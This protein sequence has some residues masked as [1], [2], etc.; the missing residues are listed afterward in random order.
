MFLYNNQLTGIITLQDMS[1]NSHQIAG[2]IPAQ[3]GIL[4]SLLHTRF[5]NN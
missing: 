3:L 5:C 2:L 4:N 1:H